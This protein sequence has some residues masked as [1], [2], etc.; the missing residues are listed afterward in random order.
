MRVSG[1]TCIAHIGLPAQ[2]ASA[3]RAEV[4]VLEACAGFINLA[5]Q[6]AF[7][8]GLSRPGACGQHLPYHNQS[9][10][11]SAERSSLL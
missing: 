4:E 10:P 1:L 5:G 11:D 3:V 8:C 6:S 9:V 2:L 7:G